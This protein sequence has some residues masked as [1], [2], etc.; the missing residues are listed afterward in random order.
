MKYK[1]PNGQLIGEYQ[2]FTYEDIQ[3]P[4]NWIALST[5][6]E[7]DALGLIEV[8]EAVRADDRFYLN[9][10]VNTPKDLD[11]LKSQWIGQIKQTAGS[12]LTQTDWMV[13]RKIERDIAIPLDVSTKRLAVLTEANRLEAAIQECADVPAL[14]VVVTTQN[15]PE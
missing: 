11:Q 8:E 13:I 15:W 1:L 14:I 4:E 6:E 2:A 9:G 10:D 12:M 5:Q 7:R 3:Y